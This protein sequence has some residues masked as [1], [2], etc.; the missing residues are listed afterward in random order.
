MNLV[1]FKHKSEK[2]WNMEIAQGV[3]RNYALVYEGT[4]KLT[5]EKK[6]EKKRKEK[7]K[8]K[9]N[10]EKNNEKKRKKKTKRKNTKTKYWK[11]KT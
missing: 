7:K 5:N 11:N 3:L 1:I 10:I 2:Y 4:C 8:R 9:E 6:N